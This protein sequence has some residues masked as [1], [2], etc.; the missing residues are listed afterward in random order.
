MLLVVLVLSSA[1]SRESG[2]GASAPTPTH[3]VGPFCAP[4]PTSQ[5]LDPSS[6]KSERDVGELGPSS[7][8]S[9]T[10]AE[11]QLRR[12]TFHGWNTWYLAE[13]MAHYE[14]AR[15]WED[16][17]TT[18]AF[19]LSRTQSKVREQFDY[20]S[21]SGSFRS[22]TYEDVEEVPT[23]GSPTISIDFFRDTELL[24][25]LRVTFPD[26]SGEVTHNVTAGKPLQWLTLND[27]QQVSSESTNRSWKLDIRRSGNALK[28]DVMPVA[29]QHEVDFVTGWFA[30]IK[31]DAM[32]PP[33]R[34]ISLSAQVS[35]STPAKTLR[36]NY[37]LTYC[38]DGE[39]PCKF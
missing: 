34:I 1:C 10:Q 26:R 28:F 15:E 8:Q 32:A 30:E 24:R 37:D 12:P 35:Q 9:P 2:N 20:L 7:N 19:Y 18:V 31:G 39:D 22:K 29:P 17:D 11:N 21:L 27:G 4:N 23:H 6:E 16:F 33:W 14:D 3:C 25:A 38:A 5:I 36:F 13:G